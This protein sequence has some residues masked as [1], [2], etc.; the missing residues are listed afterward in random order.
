MYIL[1]YKG[2]FSVCPRRIG[3]N[4]Q[5]HLKFHLPENSSLLDFLKD[6]TS[7]LP[8]HNVS[9]WIC[10]FRVKSPTAAAKR[11]YGPSSRTCTLPGAKG[12]GEET[13]LKTNFRN[14]QS[15]TQGI[16]QMKTLLSPWKTYQHQGP[17]FL[18]HLHKCQLRNEKPRYLC[19]SGIR[20]KVVEEEF[21]SPP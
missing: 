18:G 2:Q 15:G 4:W 11:M 19:L 13:P 17:L 14:H 5:C 3:S 10:M 9:D 21:I 7:S 12:V 20:V 1:L 8:L 16:R 6:P